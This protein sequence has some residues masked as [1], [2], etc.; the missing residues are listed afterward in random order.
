VER[1]SRPVFVLSD[2]AQEGFLSGS[3]RSI[4]CF[5]LLEALESMRHLF[6]KFGGHRQAA[7]LTIRREHV[8]EFR[9]R[10]HLFASERLTIDD[11]RPEY[12]VDA[13]SSFPELNGRTIAEIF[14]MAP[15]GFGNPA[16]VLMARGVEVAG[17]A[18][19]MGEGKHLKLALR[20]EGR[21][22]WFK[23]W[24]FGERA[25]LFEPGAKLDVL[26]T[27]DDDPGSK[28]RGYDGWSFT[29]KDARQAE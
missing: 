13:E 15:F 11:M 8:G 12:T 28:A 27:V 26:F 9:E 22:L 19:S 3:G 10:F 20:N 14:A 16:P 2:A 7:G 5:H 29:L 21:V 17:P 6:Q 18:R 1:F 24:N 25:P 23:A 4:P